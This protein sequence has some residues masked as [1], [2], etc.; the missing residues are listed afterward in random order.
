MGPLSKSASGKFYLKLQGIHS[1]GRIDVMG[2]KEIAESVHK[3]NMKVT[4]YI[5]L[6]GEY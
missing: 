5:I 4:L 3:L 1:S 6:I 2:F